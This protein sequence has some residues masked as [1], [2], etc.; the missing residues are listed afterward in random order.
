MALAVAE[1]NSQPTQSLGQGLG[2]QVIVIVA[3]RGGVG[4]VAAVGHGKVMALALGLG[5]SAG[6]RLAGWVNNY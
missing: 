1:L 2:S 3:W 6:W 5:P 4:G